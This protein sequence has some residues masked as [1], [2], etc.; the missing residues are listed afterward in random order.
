MSFIASNIVNKCR[1][2]GES[3]LFIACYKGHLDIVLQLLDK[4]V[5]T[6]VNKCVDSG[7]SPLYV[8]CQE[9]H[10]DSLIVVVQCLNVLPGKKHIKVMHH[11]LYTGLH[12]Y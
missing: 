12:L 4:K 11:C 9:G 5:N 10:L 7:E 3:P 1:D 2:S 6:D 8:A